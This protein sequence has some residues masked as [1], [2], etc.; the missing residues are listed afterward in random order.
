MSTGWGDVSLAR[1]EHRRVIR[2]AFQTADIAARQVF[3]PSGDLGYCSKKKTFYG[4][5]DLE[6]ANCGSETREPMRAGV[7][8]Q[9]GRGS[10]SGAKFARLQ[11]TVLQTVDNR[12]IILDVLHNTF[13]Q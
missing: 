5:V 13:T 6:A 8:S 7:Q 10:T 1:R 2:A 9:A 12:R 11:Q 4:P 3:I